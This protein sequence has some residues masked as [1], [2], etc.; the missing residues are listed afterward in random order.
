MQSIHYIPNSLY[1]LIE[2]HFGKTIDDIK[3]AYQNQYDDI[4]DEYIEYLNENN[5]VFFTDHPECFPAMNLQWDYP[6]KVSNAIIDWNKNSNYNIF[7]VLNQLD[8]LHCKHIQFRFYDPIEKE[9][10]LKILD[11]LNQKESIINSLEIY[12]PNTKWIR[13]EEM[14]NWFKEHLRISLICIHSSFDDEI[15]KITDDKIFIHT[16]QQIISSSH[17]GVISMNYF[18]IN[19]KTF[20]ESQHYNSCLNRKIAIDIDGEIKNC[21]S[22]T[23]SFGNIE[24]N[25]LKQTLNNS[26]FTAVWNIPKDKVDTCKTCEFRYICT[27]CRAYTEDPKN[28][29]SKPLKCGYNPHTNEWK[30]WSTNPL[31]KEAIHYYKLKDFK[32]T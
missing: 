23:Q 13:Q 19:L 6:Y 31:K 10:L 4:I 3:E 5:C 32:Q 8:M 14:E 1:E 30:D 18:S 16:K 27:D 15:I 26:D 9:F 25:T 24:N 17:C 2:D 28:L 21:P 29:N 12:I 20:T 11:F 7:E 22:M